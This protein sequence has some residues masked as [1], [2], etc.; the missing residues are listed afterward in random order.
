MGWRFCVTRLLPLDDCLYALRATIPHPTASDATGDVAFLLG[1]ASQETVA[2]VRGSCATGQEPAH[3]AVLQVAGVVNPPDMVEYCVAALTWL[4]RDGTLGF[5]RDMRVAGTT[6]ALSFDTGFVTGF[7][8]RKE[9][10]S[11]AVP[12]WAALKPTAE[13][14]LA[15]AEPDAGLCYSIGYAYGVRTANG[16]TVRAGG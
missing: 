8:Q 9:I 4:G 7:Q 10:S 3:I 11:S 1:V 14:C 16:E 13:R 6:P 5:V 12:T 2:R 15:Q